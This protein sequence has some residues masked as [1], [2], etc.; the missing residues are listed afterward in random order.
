MQAITNKPDKGHAINLFILD[1]DPIRAAEFSFD[2]HTIKMCLEGMQMLCTNAHLLG[3][4]HESMIKS[5]HANHPSTVWGRTSSHNFAWIVANTGALFAEYTKR[6]DKRHAM[7]NAYES[8][9]PVFDA[10][11]DKLEG[12][13]RT[14]LTPFAL[15]MP[16]DCKLACPVASYRKYYAHKA[17]QECDKLAVYDGLVKRG[18]NPRKPALR[19]VWQRGN[20]P[21]W[22]TFQTAQHI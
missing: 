21:E 2:S 10:C 7:Q 4:E 22:A 5:T 8:L 12:E 17:K 18:C 13:G 15:A 3:F 16:D 6:Y 20:R 11:C 9:L 19:F 1:F 14:E